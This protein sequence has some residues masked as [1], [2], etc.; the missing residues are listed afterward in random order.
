MLHC[1][2]IAVQFG[3]CR[4]D[5]Y[6]GEI[7]NKI[8]VRKLYCIVGGVYEC[9]VK[10]SNYKFATCH[11]GI[12]VVCPTPP[13]WTTKGKYFSLLSHLFMQDYYGWN[14]KATKVCLHFHKIYLQYRVDMLKHPDFREKV[15][16]CDTRNV[17]YTYSLVFR[18]VYKVL[19]FPFSLYATE[20]LFLQLVFV[21]DLHCSYTKVLSSFS[22][23]S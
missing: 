20:V 2:F 13:Y 23:E 15:V 1:F 17:Y 5:N 9:A 12:H 6:Y 19:F 18:R 11:I 22:R 16:L 8:R 21:Y 7:I 4:L 3:Y 10:F 14:Y